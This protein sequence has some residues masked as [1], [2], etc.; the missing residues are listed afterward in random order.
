MGIAI[1]EGNR[2]HTILRHTYDTYYTADKALTFCLIDV[3]VQMDVNVLVSR[4][5]TFND[6]SY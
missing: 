3:Y 5:D 1:I 6:A 2:Q 4:S